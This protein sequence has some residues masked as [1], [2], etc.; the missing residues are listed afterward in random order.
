M[1]VV[2]LPIGP[3]R[4]QLPFV[5]SPTPVVCVPHPFFIMEASTGFSGKCYSCG[6]EGHRSSDCPEGGAAAG[7]ALCRCRA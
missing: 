2:A 6:Q 4:T 7:G 3:A 5:F 1:I